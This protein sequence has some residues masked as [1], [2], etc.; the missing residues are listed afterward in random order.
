MTAA[1][2]A[3]CVLAIAGLLTLEHHGHHALVDWLVPAFVL[4]AAMWLLVIAAGGLAVQ[5]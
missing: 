1:L 3:F 5:W 4:T 2:V